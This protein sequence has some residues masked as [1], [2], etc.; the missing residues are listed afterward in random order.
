MTTI[1]LT[2]M[3]DLHGPSAAWPPRLPLAQALDPSSGRQ[4]VQGGVEFQ[5]LDFDFQND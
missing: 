4:A 2:S 3:P 1:D 5:W